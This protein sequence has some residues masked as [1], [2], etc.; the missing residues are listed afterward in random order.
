MAR[1]K[2]FSVA[3]VGE[4]ER[5]IGQRIAQ[6][7]VEAGGMAQR[8]LADLLGVSER[9]VQAYEAG[10]VVPYRYFKELERI[11]GR[12]MAW[13]LH[14]EDAV[15]ARDEQHEA[16]MAELRAVRRE[17]SAIKKLLPKT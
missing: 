2:E 10:E 5:A 4:K 1:R 7:R 13:L 15:V 16:V 6:A 11:L 17:L 8:E 3:N 12:P 14:G 9:S